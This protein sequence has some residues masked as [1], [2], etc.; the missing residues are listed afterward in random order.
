MARDFK[1]PNWLDRRNASAA[2][3]DRDPAVLVVGGGQAGL[4]IAARLRQ[5][6]VD[7]LVVDRAGRAGDNWRHLIFTSTDM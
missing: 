1:G 2:Y 6:D 3:T 5:L 4:C 7:T